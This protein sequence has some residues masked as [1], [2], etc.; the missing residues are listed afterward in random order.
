MWRQE[1]Q[2]RQ[3]A[4]EMARSV[5]SLTRQAGEEGLEYQ[6]RGCR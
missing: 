5:W 2:E 4:V 6:L 3:S 1:W